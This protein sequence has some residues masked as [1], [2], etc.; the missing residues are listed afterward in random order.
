MILIIDIILKA[1]LLLF[2]ILFLGNTVNI[3]VYEG[4]SFLSEIKYINL[5]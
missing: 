1:V 5:Q 2:S 3:F 4:V